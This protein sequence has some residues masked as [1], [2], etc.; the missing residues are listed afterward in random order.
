MTSRLIESK[1]AASTIYENV[2]F[3]L[4]DKLLHHLKTYKSDAGFQRSKE[5][6]HQRMEDIFYSA[7]RMDLQMNKQWAY[8]TIHFPSVHVPDHNGYQTGLPFNGWNMAVDPICGIET[9]GIVGLVM[10]PT[11]FVVG[12]NNGSGFLDGARVLERSVVMPLGALSKEFE[13]T[14]R[15]R[16]QGDPHQGGKRPNSRSQQ[17]G[18]QKPRNFLGF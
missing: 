12:K 18:S 14:R 6:Y 11:L 15:G 2:N 3:E 9:C 16:N 4:I 8:Y 7:I 5:E 10:T 1:T 17:G 13:E